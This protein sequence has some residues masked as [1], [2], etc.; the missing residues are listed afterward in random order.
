MLLKSPSSNPASTIWSNITDSGATVSTTCQSLL[1]REQLVNMMEVAF[2]K[3]SQP[4]F[5]GALSMT[6]SW[7]DRYI[8]IICQFILFIFLP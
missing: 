5:E 6:P 2:K 7:H 4:I 8:T 3:V 1:N